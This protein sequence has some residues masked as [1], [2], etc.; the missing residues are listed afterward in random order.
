MSNSKQVLLHVNLEDPQDNFWLLNPQLKVTEPFKSTWKLDKD[1]DKKKSSEMMFALAMVYDPASKYRNLP[2]A[3][4]ISLLEE[5][6]LSGKLKIDKR[7]P[8]LRPY[9]ADGA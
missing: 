8:A 6:Y 7:H 3:D 4:R 9:E 5:D 2:E 1:K